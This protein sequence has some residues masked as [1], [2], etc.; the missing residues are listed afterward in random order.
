VVSDLRTCVNQRGTLYRPLRRR[1]GQHRH[2]GEP[3]VTPDRTETLPAPEDC[4]GCGGD[5]A[6]AADAGMSWAQVWD[7]PPIVMEKVDYLLPRWG[8]PGT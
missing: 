2:P 7:L 4:S 1:S 3:T 8:Q 5:L 6:N